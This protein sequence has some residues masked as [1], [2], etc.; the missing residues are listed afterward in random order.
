MSS[1]LH[2][3]CASNKVAARRALQDSDLDQEL[4]CWTH[5]LYAPRRSSEP[6][7]LL[8]LAERHHPSERHQERPGASFRLLLSSLVKPD[9]CI[10]FAH[11]ACARRQI[12]NLVAEQRLWPHRI[13]FDF[14]LRFSKSLVSSQNCCSPTIFAIWRVKPTV[15]YSFYSV[16]NATGTRKT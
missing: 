1:N 15:L 5:K 8:P 12:D 6:L 4:C 7:V 10:D 16:Q 9:V 11:D 3:V 13:T 2:A 14:G